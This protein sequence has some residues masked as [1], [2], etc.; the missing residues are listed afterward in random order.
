MH[1]SVVGY[2]VAPATMTVVSDSVPG[3]DVAGWQVNLADKS[4]PVVCRIP[5]RVPEA[6][7]SYLTAAGIAA[8]L[9]A[10]WA[11]LCVI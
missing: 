4:K 10:T 5:N 2:D 1:Q 9:V 7:A 8:G 6:L 11:A 3:R